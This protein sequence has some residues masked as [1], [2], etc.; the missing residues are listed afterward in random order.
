MYSEKSNLNSLIILRHNY[1]MSLK[2]DLT[3]VFVSFYSK[4]LIE[5][6]ISQINS[7]IPIIV[8]ENSRDFKLKDVLEKKY[9]N[10]T[11]IIP[12]QNTGNGGGANIGL[13]Y[14]KS[15]FVLYLDVDVNLSS[16]LVD[17]LYSHAI[18]LDDFSI[19]GP[20]IEGLNYED[21]Y[22][23]KK[24]FTD[25]VHI[26]NFIT[27][28][29]LFFNMNAMKKIGYFDENIFLYYEENDLYLRSLKKNYKIYLI[30]EAKIKHVGNQSTDLIHKQ[31]VE[32]NRN[33]HLMWSTF[34]FHKKHFGLITAYK[35]TF[36]KLISASVKFFIF[37]I[38]GKNSYKKIYFARMSGIFNA[39]I[40][41]K[42]WFRTN[43]D[44]IIDN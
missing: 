37:S 35:K 33:W 13:R 16:N 26:M 6:P 12:D 32:I 4:N 38:L 2:K 10:V 23:I 40:G 20:S 44:K 15:R 1:Q 9:S 34:Y 25:K 22:Y 39:M 43:L 7:D 8:V 36:F 27:G 30:E 14:T 42:S 41:N 28:C 24:N 19:L 18:K 17:K 11:V 31:E 3:I 21:N 29:A 5:K